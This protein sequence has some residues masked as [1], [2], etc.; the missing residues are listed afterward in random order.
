MT[1]AIFRLYGRTNSGSHVVQV[2]L[3]EIGA[4]YEVLWL[5]KSPAAIESLRRVN[6]AARVP[7][8]VLPEGTPVTESAAI[9]TYL[10]TA[11]PGA[12]LAPAVGTPAH[13]LF[14][15]WMVYLSANVYDCA[16]RYFYAERYSK[17]GA[18][19]APGIQARALEEYTEAL[20]RLAAQLSPYLLGET[21]SAADPY[22]YMLAG[23]HP[24][25]AVLRERWPQL[26]RHAELMRQRPAIRKADEAHTE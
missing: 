17:A 16:L 20:Q 1:E 9:L 11:F 7:V 22:L 5:D 23:W 24:D 8:L 14:L 4:P 12:R 18:E 26:A 13:A 15:Q 3:E 10:S 19:A 21:Y 2:L 6:P 25:L